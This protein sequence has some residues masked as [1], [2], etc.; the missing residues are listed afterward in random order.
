MDLKEIIKDYKNFPK[1]GITFR[2]FTPLLNNPKA[3]NFVITYFKDIS[4]ELKP[5][6]IVGIESRGFIIGSVLANELGIGFVPIRKKGKLPGEIVSI[7]YQLEYGTD[8]LEIKR[9]SL[10]KE[11]RI[12]I[13]DDLL[14]TGGTANA[15]INLVKKLDAKVIS[16]FF[17]IELTGL[18]GRDRLKDSSEIFSMVKY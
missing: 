1:K 2:D 14:A 18:N 9:D 11:S 6:K 5:D 16:A 17:I 10:S 15:A 13:T 4:K 3:W 8:E 12:I 7:K